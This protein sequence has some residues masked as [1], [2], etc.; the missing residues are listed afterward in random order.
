MASFS[1]PLSGLDAYAQALSTV[2]NNLANLNTTAFKSET[3]QFSD[4]FYQQIG[5]AGSGDPVQVGVGSRI[6]SMESDFTQGS[7]ESTGVNTDVAIQG[8]GFFVLNNNGLVTYSR[9]G[10]FSINQ[11]G[12]LTSADGS[13]VQGFPAVNGVVDPNGTL[14]AINV[15]SDLISPPNA[16]AKVTLGLNLDA[17]AATGTA[18]S[19]PVT[20]YDALG[21]SHVATFNFTKS[22]ANTWNFTVTVPA[23]DLGQ[24]GAPVALTSS[25]STLNFNGSGVLTTA[26]PISITMPAGDSWANGATVPATLFQWQLVDGNGNSV[27][28]QVAGASATASINQDGYASGSLTDFT[29]ANDGTIEGTFSNGRSAALGQLALAQFANL[30]GMNRNGN[31]EYLASIGSGPA[32]VGTPGTGGRG[33]LSGGALELSNANISS[34]FTQLI[35]DE[36]GF[37][38]N[39]RAITTFDNITQESLNLIHP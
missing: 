33:T 34:E 16:T 35:M 38:A 30:Q 7:T 2:S 13:L 20:I 24:V 14:G 31:N 6:G 10:N 4:L 15:G 5:S 11:Q 26:G 27:I 28:S 9:A 19:T 12:L 29:V 32:T 23:A 3:P 39:A 21:A 18:F 8:N 36:R 17:S 37:Q 22:A 1:I 25:T